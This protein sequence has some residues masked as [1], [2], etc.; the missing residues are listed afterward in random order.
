MEE[1]DL[2]ASAPHRRGI[3]RVGH[4]AAADPA[5]R[6]SAQAREAG[7]GGPTARLPGG[8]AAWRPA[9]RGPALS[10]RYQ[11]RAV[12][13]PARVF[14]CLVEA[15]FTKIDL[16]TLFDPNVFVPRGRLV[17]RF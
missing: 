12:W 6:A 4:A 5:H 1:H 11:R 14:V 8:S 15:M 9:G 3:S 13:W 10:P 17:Y 16:R 2:I 7:L